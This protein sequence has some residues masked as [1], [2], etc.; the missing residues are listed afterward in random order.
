MKLSEYLND[1]AQLMS[2]PTYSF[3][4]KFQMTRWINEARRLLSMRTG[5]IQRLITGQSAFGAGDQAGF[6]IPGAAQPG[7]VPGAFD[8]GMG[9]PAGG[10][11]FGTPV[12]GASLGPMTTIVNVERY[13]YVGF[14]NPYLK[15]QHAGCDKV[16]DVV[17]VA[18]SWGGASKPALNWMPWDDFQAYCRSVA[19]LNTSYP[20]VWST[21][22]DGSQGEVWLFPIPSQAN[23]MEVQAT[24][25]PS[26]LYGESDFEAIPE[27]FTDTI[28]FGAAALCYFSKKQ[29]G[30]A[31]IMDQQGGG[32]YLPIQRAAADRGKSPS[33]YPGR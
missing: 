23:D 1:T 7:A 25:L 30:N 22:N 17:S 26:P 12:V 9:G 33:Y 14:F 8:Y 20:A 13:P 6:A 28:K 11:N 3:T 5:C 32:I 4:S 2:D 21:L 31:Q 19:V 27:S 15:A 24:C 16:N 29:F 10:L 18:V